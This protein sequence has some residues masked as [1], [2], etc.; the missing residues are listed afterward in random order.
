M[1]NSQTFV[2]PKRGYAF[3]D[4]DNTLIRINSM[5]SFQD[6]WYDLYPDL[7][8]ESSYRADLHTHLHSHACW[9]TVNKLYYRHFAGRSVTALSQAGERWFR[10]CRSASEFY[11][12][13]V[14]DELRQHQRAGYQVVFVSGSFPAVLSPIARELG[15]TQILA[16]QLEQQEGVVTGYL[17]APPMVGAGK[18]DAIRSLLASQG[19][20]E[21]SYAYGDDVSDIPMLSVVGNPVVVAGGRLS[22]AQTKKLGWRLIADV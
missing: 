22:P 17:T 6:F 18:R 12:Q 3:F 1:S 8:A 21:V 7:N 11:C 5:L 20:A 15:V 10:H 9:E 14:L 2:N 4:V 13:P 19:I 16:T